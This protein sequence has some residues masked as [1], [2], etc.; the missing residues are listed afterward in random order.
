V[1]PTP[2][3]TASSPTTIASPG[4]GSSNKSTNIGIVTGLG[5]FIVALVVAAWGL[6]KHYKNK[7]ESTEVSMKES[8]HEMV[9]KSTL[10]NSGHVTPSLPNPGSAAV[11]LYAPS[12]D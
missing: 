3:A 9:A 12:V 4:D 1:S 8:E 6:Y 11:S 10:T 5:S 7:K 2:A